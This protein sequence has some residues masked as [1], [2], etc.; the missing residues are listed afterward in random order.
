MSATVSWDFLSWWWCAAASET[1]AQNARIAAAMA[2]VKCILLRR[3]F[4]K[5]VRAQQTLVCS[6]KKFCRREERKKEGKR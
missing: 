5:Q 3:M 6:K 4:G 2:E 1:V